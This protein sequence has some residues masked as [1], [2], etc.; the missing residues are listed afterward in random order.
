MTKL[1][2]RKNRQCLSFSLSLTFKQSEAHSLSPLTRIL[3]RFV[4]ATTCVVLLYNR[5][6]YFACD[7]RALPI[8]NC[9]KRELVTMISY[10]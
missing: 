8:F 3:F 5:I 10:C 7:G 6:V 4:K 1:S 9:S 2:L